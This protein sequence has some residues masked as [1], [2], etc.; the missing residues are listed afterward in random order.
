[1]YIC[2]YM[3]YI[4]YYIKLYVYIICSNSQQVISI[5]YIRAVAHA[6]QSGVSPR[7]PSF[8]RCSSLKSH[9]C[10]PCWRPAVRG[11]DSDGDWCRV[12]KSRCIAQCSSTVGVLIEALAAYGMASHPQSQSSQSQGRGNWLH[13]HMRMMLLIVINAHISGHYLLDLCTGNPNVTHFNYT[14]R[15]PE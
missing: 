9:T 4:W 2:M 15:I 13:Y 11:M 5:C 1:M 14:V 3:Y 6:C 7:P 8:V 10:L 12:V